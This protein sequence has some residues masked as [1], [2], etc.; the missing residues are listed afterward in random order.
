MTINEIIAIVT[1]V[2][3]FVNLGLTVY[4]FMKYGK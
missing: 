1:F 2:A 3:V 4:N